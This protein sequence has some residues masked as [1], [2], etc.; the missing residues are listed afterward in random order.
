[1]SGIS[2]CEQTQLLLLTTHKSEMI[3]HAAQQEKCLLPATGSDA[4]FQ[5]V[6]LFHSLPLQHW[7]G[8]H[9][10]SGRERE[11][12]CLGE[13]AGQMSIQEICKQIQRL[14]SLVGSIQDRLAIRAMTN[15]SEVLKRCIQIFNQRNYYL[16][17][18]LGIVIKN[19]HM[20]NMML[21]SAYVSFYVLGIVS[22]CFNY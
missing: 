12:H 10:Q 22:A 18:I 9:F 21:L 3:C 15:C 16:S 13:N 8:V 20:L 2:N 1:V 11:K 6:C 17:S 5:I 7:K 19:K 14:S 4:G